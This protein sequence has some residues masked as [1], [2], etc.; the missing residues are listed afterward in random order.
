MSARGG[1]KKR[2]THVVNMSRTVVRKE[3]Y[4][5]KGGNMR[6]QYLAEHTR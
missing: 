3:A 6:D 4:Y 5:R 1:R 2:L